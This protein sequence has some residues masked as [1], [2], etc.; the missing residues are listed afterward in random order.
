MNKTETSIQGNPATQTVIFRSEEHKKFFDEN[1]QKCRYKDVYNMALIY[2]LGI[3]RDTR[4][5]IDSEYDFH[6]SCIKTEC[7]HDGWITSGSARIIRLAFNLFCNGTPSVSDYE[8]NT[9]DA[10]AEAR[11]YSVEDL[12][13]C[14]Y[15]KY[16]WQAIQIRYPEYC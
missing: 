6:T 4:E 15:A 14:G 7:L 13:C 11:R 9:L 3:D 10:V 1:I 5:H 8:G 12:F 2:T 16:F